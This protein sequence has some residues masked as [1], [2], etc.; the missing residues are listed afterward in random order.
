MSSRTPNHVPP[1][2]PRNKPLPTD[3]GPD[4]VVHGTPGDDLIDA[5]YIDPQGDQVDNPDQDWPGRG[6]L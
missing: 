2:G 6:P 1:A 4:G 5:D 3:G